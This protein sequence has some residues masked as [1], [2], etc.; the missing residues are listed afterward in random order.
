MDG[1][2]ERKL[3]LEQKQEKEKEFLNFLKEFRNKKPLFKIKEEQYLHN[4]VE[5]Q[6]KKRQLQ[7]EE[8]HNL[9]KSMKREDFIEHELNYKKLKEEKLA[10]QA[11]ER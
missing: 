6:N 2:E 3:E 8:I 9:K 4:V 5:E 11:A 7:L 10:Q 1:R